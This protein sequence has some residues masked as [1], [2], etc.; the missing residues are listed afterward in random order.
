MEVY[1]WENRHEV[2]LFQ[3]LGGSSHLLSSLSHLNYIKIISLVIMTHC[4]PFPPIPRRR[5]RPRQ[6]RSPNVKRLKTRRSR[7]WSKNTCF[8]STSFRTLAFHQNTVENDEKGDI[9]NEY[10]MRLLNFKDRSI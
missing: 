4:F 2:P 5:Q 10:Q 6:S 1:S 7:A 9:L 3:L 8:F